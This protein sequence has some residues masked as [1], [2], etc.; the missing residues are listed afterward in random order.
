MTKKYL[1]LPSL[2]TLAALSFSTAHAVVVFTENFDNTSGSDKNF[3]TVGWS[4]VHSATGTAYATNTTTNV[5]IVSSAA[6][7]TGAAPAGYLFHNTFQGNDPVMYYV[8]GLNLGSP[9][10]GEKLDTVT[11][12]LRNVSTTENIQIALQFGAGND[13]FLGDSIYNNTAS[14]VWTTG[15]TLD[16]SAE[17]WKALTVNVG[18]T[19]T[20]GSAASLP[21]FNTSSLTGIGF[22]TA[23]TGN[24]NYIRIDTLAING[25]IPEPSTYATL[26]G[27]LALGFVML[28]RRRS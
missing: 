25:V 1:R 23:T 20:I 3:D 12:A 22:Y 4:S 16:L 8:A 11:F 14:S 27:G 13:W 5:P 28:R 6:S 10:G 18:T 26:A 7:S 2:I 15:L 17:T 21:T 9:V 24:P 19:I